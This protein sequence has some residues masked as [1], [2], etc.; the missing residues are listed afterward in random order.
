MALRVLLRDTSV[1][2]LEPALCWTAFRCINLVVT[3]PP[4]KLLV[5]WSRWTWE[6]IQ[7]LIVLEMRRTSESQHG[8][9]MVTFHLC[10]S[11]N[12]NINFPPS[13][14]MHSCMGHLHTF[15]SQTLNSFF[16]ILQQKDERIIALE[17]ENAMLYL[18]LAQVSVVWVKLVNTF[19]CN[20][21]PFTYEKNK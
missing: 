13:Q 14:A 1:A 17:T 21:V 2:A 11:T 6:L 10:W 5:V 7:R 20:P 8:W 12:C 18:K 19:H 4:R 9:W 3:G 16:V 15:C